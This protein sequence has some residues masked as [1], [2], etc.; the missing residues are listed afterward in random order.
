MANM[1]KLAFII[2]GLLTACQAM[3]MSANK[4]W[5]EFRDDGRYRVTA[6]Y[7]IAELKELREVYVDFT[8]RKRAEEFYWY[9]VRGGDFHREMPEVDHFHPV[10]LTPNPW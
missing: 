8:S 9:L 7:T 3:A 10:K 4:V 1:A 6:Q 2:I 5:F